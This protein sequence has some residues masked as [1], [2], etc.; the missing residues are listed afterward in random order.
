MLSFMS[1]RSHPDARSLPPQAQEA[2][3]RRAVL[4][5]RDGMSKV[6]A[7]RTF[8]VSRAAIHNWMDRVEG[9]NIRSLKSRKR[10]RPPEPRLEPHEIATTV[11]ILTARCP[12]QMYL[13]FAL[14]TRE[15]VLELLDRRFG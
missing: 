2:L 7:A 11:R 9:G 12:D 1:T 15:A 6:D 5:V 10:G 4:A 14:W 13:P 8:G 3:R